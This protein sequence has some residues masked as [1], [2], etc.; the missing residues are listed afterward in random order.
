MSKGKGRYRHLFG[1]VPSRRFGLSLGVDL[2]PLKTCSFNCIFCQLGP[3]TR[4]TVDRAEYVPVSEV[5]AELERWSREGAKCDY[6]TLSGSGEP[7]LHSRFGEVLD[8]A[9]QLRKARTALLTNGTLL[10]CEEVRKQAVRADVVKV[11]LSAWDDASLRAVNRPAPGIGWD[12]LVSGIRSFRRHFSGELWMEVFLVPGVNDDPTGVAKIAA[13][14]DSLEPTKVHLN[15]AV[16]PA[17]DRGIGRMSLD[18]MRNLARLFQSPTEVIGEYTGEEPVGTSATRDRILDML[19]RRPCTAEDLARVFGLHP[20]EVS[21]HLAKLSW[22]RK[23]A[24]T[25]VGGRKYYRASGH[26]V[27]GGSA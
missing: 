21:K 3:T 4:L 1:P 13:V 12:D 25:E 8:F 6:V 26:D 19:K 15:T 11:S 2:I 9:R 23:I 10:G 7:T 16:R 17:A 22:Q 24:A 27:N 14:V 5:T 18:A 20:N